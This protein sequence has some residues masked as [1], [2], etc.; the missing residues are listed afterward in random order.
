MIVGAEDYPKAHVYDPEYHWH[1]HLIG[2]KKCKPVRCQ[3][4]NLYKGK[5]TC[6]YWGLQ[7]LTGA[8]RISSSAYYCDTLPTW[9]L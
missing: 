9:G 8:N 1:L 2:V 4:P 7:G 6:Y 3:V 5:V